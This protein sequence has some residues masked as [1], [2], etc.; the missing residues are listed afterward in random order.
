MTSRSAPSLMKGQKV[1]PSHHPRRPSPLAIV[2]MAAGLCCATAAYGAS[3][4]Y[5]TYKGAPVLGQIGP[6]EP[7]P[8]QPATFGKGGGA[9]WSCQAG[10]CSYTKVSGAAWSNCFVS[11]SPTHGGWLPTRFCR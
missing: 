4:P 6:P 10:K 8:T 5:P 11:Y 3:P 9:D 7:S 1:N 2:A